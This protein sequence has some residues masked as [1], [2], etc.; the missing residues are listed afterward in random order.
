MSRLD[1]DTSRSPSTHWF[2]PLPRNRFFTGREAHLRSL[3]EHFHLPADDTQA[4]IQVICGAGGIGKTQIAL[5]YAYRFRDD[6][7]TVTLVAYGNT[8]N[9]ARRSDSTDGLP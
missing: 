2:V 3:H 1:T 7:A 8:G 5:E 9:V 6:Y 4:R